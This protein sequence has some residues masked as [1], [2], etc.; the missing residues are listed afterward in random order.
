VR[1]HE[2]AYDLPLLYGTLMV[3]AMGLLMVTSASM[4]IAEQHA[5]SPFYYFFKQ[6]M[7]LLVSGGCAYV[8]TRV[9]IVCWHRCHGWLMVASFMMLILVMVPGVGHEVNG[10]VRWLRFGPVS[11]QVSELTKCFVI[12]YLSGYLVRHRFAFE[13]TALGWMRPL[14]LLL[15]TGGLLLLEPDFGSTV[16]I[17]MT[18]FTLFFLAGL[19][20][21][22]VL[23]L[24][25]LLLV[26]FTALIVVAPYR[27]ERLTAFL[28][29]WVNQY[30]SGYQ[31]TQA[32]IAFGRGGIWGAGLGNGLQKL[33][34]LPEAHTDFL[35]AVLAEE[36][37][38]LGC[39]SV[40]GAYGL[41]MWRG[42]CIGRMAY[43]KGAL[44]HAYMAYGFG[45]CLGAQALVNLGVNLGWLPTKGLTLPL[46][47]YGGSSLLVNSIVIAIILR[48]GH[49][50]E[51][52]SISIKHGSREGRVLRKKRW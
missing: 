5:G 34:Y 45:V 11:L 2:F 42:L 40:M 21:R 50:V 35:F 28:H 16:V 38:L 23:L 14:F 15:L 31:L 36:L 12:I 33:F 6:G 32:L 7:Y 1:E 19:R 51:T 41:I 25:S 4:G 39:L 8:V 27:L 20:L 37:G 17:L 22:Y 9:P 49:E 26:A 47:S 29:P 52:D 10:S 43:Q 48:V 13:E 3:V 46:M 30:G 44:F 18:A 24:L